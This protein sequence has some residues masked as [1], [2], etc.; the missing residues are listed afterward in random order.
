MLKHADK[1]QVP[2][3]ALIGG[4]AT[5][6]VSSAGSEDTRLACSAN[7]GYI[8]KTSV[9][10]ISFLRSGEVLANTKATWIKIQNRICCCISNSGHKLKIDARLTAN[11]VYLLIQQWH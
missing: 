10:F 8:V 6:P 2:L 3:I 4:V 9:I 1:C 7:G 11:I 5:L